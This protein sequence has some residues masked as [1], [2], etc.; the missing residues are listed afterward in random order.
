MR[1]RSCTGSLTR[2]PLAPV[3]GVASCHP[4]GSGHFTTVVQETLSGPVTA[5][6]VQPV[7]ATECRGN[8]LSTRYCCS[9]RKQREWVILHILAPMLGFLC[10]IIQVLVVLFFQMLLSHRVSF[11]S[12]QWHSL[13]C[14]AKNFL[15]IRLSF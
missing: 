6:T 15:I 5:K 13:K 8:I 2:C 11:K 14:L 9:Q 7:R 12:V 3:E 10:R 4:Y 1:R